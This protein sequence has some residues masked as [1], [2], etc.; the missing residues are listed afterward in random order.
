MVWQAG[1]VSVGSASSRRPEGGCH[2]RAGE[3][4][5]VGGLLDNPLGIYIF[6]DPGLY[7]V[8][9]MVQKSRCDSRGVWEGRQAGIGFGGGRK[10]L[11]DLARPPKFAET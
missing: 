7:S 8:P 5:E 10:C 3:I 1:S 4:H 9:N 6:I 2:R 11:Y